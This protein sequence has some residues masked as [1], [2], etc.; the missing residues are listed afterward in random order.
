MSDISK[1]IRDIRAKAE[2][3][4]DGPAE[5]GD[6]IP[7]AELIDDSF[8]GMTSGRSQIALRFRFLTGRSVA[9]PYALLNQV[10]LEPSTELTLRYLHCRVRLRGRNMQELFDRL[11]EQRVRSIEEKDELHALANPENATVVTKIIVEVE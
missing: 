2:Q 11:A 6:E 10:E 1:V 5:V 8:Q 9:L 3:Q 4:A 7:V